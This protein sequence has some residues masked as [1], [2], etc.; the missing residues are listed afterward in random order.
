MCICVCVTVLITPIIRKINAVITRV[1]PVTKTH[2]RLIAIHWE[3]TDLCVKATETEIVRVLRKKNRS[4][5]ESASPEAH[6][7][8]SSFSTI[9]PRHLQVKLRAFATYG[10]PRAG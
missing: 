5:V 3:R 2:F 4:A 1:Q 10:I 9:L 7:P 6:P 8:F